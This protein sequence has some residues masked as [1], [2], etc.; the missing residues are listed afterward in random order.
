MR[1]YGLEQHFVTVDVT[2]ACKGRDP[3]LAEPM[4]K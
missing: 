4:M 2:E 1:L 3:R